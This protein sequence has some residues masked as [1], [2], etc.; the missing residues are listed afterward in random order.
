M[1]FQCMIDIDCLK[2]LVPVV[3]DILVVNV[4]DVHVRKRAFNYLN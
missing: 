1:Q 4:L 2:S 3:V